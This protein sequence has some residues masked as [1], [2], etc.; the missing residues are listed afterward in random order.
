M[1]MSYRGKYPNKVREISSAQ[2]KTIV[3]TND[4]KEYRVKPLYLSAPM[5]RLGDI[6]E[7]G[8]VYDGKQGIPLAN[9]E[10]I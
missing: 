3:R 5:P 10:L 4:G 7:F 8:R 2:G 6:V 9:A 1:N